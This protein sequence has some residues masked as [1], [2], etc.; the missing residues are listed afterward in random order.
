MNNHNEEG[1]RATVNSQLSDRLYSLAAEY[2]VS[3][4]QL[5]HLAV[6]RL[7]DDV[8]LLRNLRAGKLKL[9]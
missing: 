9:E 3:P 4:D 1:L 2:S 5:V 7:L 8:E 6:K